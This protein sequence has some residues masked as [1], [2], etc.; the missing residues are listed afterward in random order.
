MLSTG[1][2][3][4]IV[5]S[6]SVCVKRKEETVSVNTQKNEGE[7]RK[8]EAQKIALYVQDIFD[9]E[10]PSPDQ[11]KEMEAAAKELG[12]AGFGTIILAFLH[13]HNDGSFWYN[14]ISLAKTQ[15]FLPNII[16]TMKQPKKVSKVLLSI[17]GWKTEDFQAIKKNPA[18][19]KQQFLTWKNTLGIDGFDIDIENDYEECKTTLVDLV[20][21]GA[22]QGLTV[23]AAPYTERNYWLDIL[24]QTSSSKKPLFAWWNLQ[25]YGRA[26][27][28]DWEKEVKKVVTDAQAFLVPGY[29]IE[30]QAAPNDILSDLKNLRKTYSGISGGFLWQYEWIKKHK[31]GTVKEYA[32]A[33]QNAL[34]DQSTQ[35]EEQKKAVQQAAKRR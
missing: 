8:A 26:N 4:E 15:S 27:Y 25:L 33:L 10:N 30:Y 22:K 7:N 24:K 18:K 9:K 16:K 1:I 32:T 12:D 3:G 19:F 17:G 13:V 29:T 6:F 11:L 31:K 23:T 20:N 21:W 2:L 34:K 5:L 35:G 28:A 14:N